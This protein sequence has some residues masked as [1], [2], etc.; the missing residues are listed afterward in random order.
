MFEQRSVN[1]TPR[2]TAKPTPGISPEES[3]DLRARALQYT[4]DCYTSKKATRP[5]GLDDAK[6]IKNGCAATEQYT[7]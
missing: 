1:N 6:E 5:G 4:L 2:L 7:R 3:R